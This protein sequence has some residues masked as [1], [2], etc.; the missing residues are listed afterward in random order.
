MGEIKM[1]RFQILKKST[2]G[3]TARKGV[4]KLSESDTCAIQTPGFLTPTSRGVVPHLTPDN[5]QRLGTEICTGFSVAA[6]DFLDRLPDE[7]KIPF[8]QQENSKKLL[9]F[10]PNCPIF[11][12]PRRSSPVEVSQPN[13][14]DSIRIMTSEGTKAMPITSYFN[15]VDKFNPDVILSPPDLPNLSPGGKPGGNRI[16]KM[17]NRTEQWLQLALERWGGNKSI[18]AVVLPNVPILTQKEYLKFVGENSSRN[19][20]GL[21]FWSTHD[22]M[23][24][25]AKQEE[26]AEK[27][28]KKPSPSQDVSQKPEPTSEAVDDLIKENGLDE[29]IKFYAIGTSTPQEILNLISNGIDLFQGDCCTQF[30][31]AGV[32]LNFT[33][34]ATETHST[35][36][37]N[38]WD[39]K[40]TTDTSLLN[41]NTTGE[42]NKAYIHHLLKAREMTSWV[43]LQMNNMCA[44]EEFFK[45][46]RQS[47]EN[48]TFELDKER[49]LQIYGDEESAITFRDAFKDKSTGPTARGYAIG[50]LEQQMRQQAGNT[51]KINEPS[52][53]KL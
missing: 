16:R 51:S 34:P 53:K 37:D 29:F 23:R 21:S 45:G 42:H 38:L 8:L 32:A 40:Y 31:D 17:A 36:G 2:G 27:N 10:P 47:I 3:S 30:T 9:S 18:F 14:N 12:S 19:I 4:F 7:S 49:F 1:N 25:S 43:L 35:L 50:H 22:Y 28:K 6:E 26:V 15:F 13:S 44:M 39:D 20:S 41:P 11:M 33:F 52:F 5:I 24:L 46:I 48:G